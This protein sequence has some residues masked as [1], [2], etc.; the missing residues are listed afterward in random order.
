MS[1]NHGVW[2]TV[3]MPGKRRRG[4]RKTGIGSTAKAKAHK[5]TLLWVLQNPPEDFDG[6]NA[7]LAEAMGLSTRQVTR[8]L[9]QLV[10]ENRL[11]LE[12]TINRLASGGIRTTRMMQV[13][14]EENA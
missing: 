7:K 5:K 14:K 12:Y 1:E 6:S 2:V 3:D 10:A 8:Y 11:K 13:L 9:K 4:R